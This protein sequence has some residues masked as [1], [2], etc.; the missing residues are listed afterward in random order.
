MYSSGGECCGAAKAVRDASESSKTCGDG[1]ISATFITGGCSVTCAAGSTLGDCEDAIDLQQS[2]L[3][4]D[5]SQG[6]EPQHCILC[7]SCVM[8]D[9]QSANC[10]SRIATT[11]SMTNVFFRTISLDSRVIRRLESRNRMRS[12]HNSYSGRPRDQPS[13]FS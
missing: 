5:G 11:A 4:F 13:V 12:C 6:I 7:W 1:K 2:W 3:W 10:K 9:I 8:A